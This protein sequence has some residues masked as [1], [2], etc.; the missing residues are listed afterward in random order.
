MPSRACMCFTLPRFDARSLQEGTS[1]AWIIPFS[2]L[3]GE[4]VDFEFDEDQLGLQAAAAEV[5]AKEC[6]ASYLRSVVDDGHDP[7]DLWSDLC[8]LDWPGLAI[9]A[10]AR[11]R[12]C[13]RRRA[14]DRAR[15]ARLRRRSHPVPGH[16]V[17]VRAGGCRCGDAEQRRRFLGPVATEG[18]VGALALVGAASSDRTWDPGS[19]AVEARQVGDQWELRGTASFV[20]DGDRAAE[21][22]VL[23]SDGQRRGGVRRTGNSR[24]E[25]AAPPPW[26]RPCT[27]PRSTSTE[28]RW[29]T[30]GGWPASTCRAGFE[31]ALDEA[32]TGLAMMIVGACQRALDMVDRVR[33]RPRAVRRADRVVPGGQA[34][35]RRH[36]RRHR[37]GPSARLLRRPARSPRTTPRRS[38]GRVD[39][40]GGGGRRTEAS[41]SSTASSCSAAS[42]SPGRTICTCTCAGRRPGSCSSE[43]QPSTGRG[44]AAGLRRRRAPE[45]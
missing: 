16:H 4:G 25:L 23:A 3:E 22:A 10:D 43:E 24:S 42:A 14:G 15:A 21:L 7:S 20:I 5:L 11:R 27:S 8:A 29:A 40:Q 19:P 18:R 6:P 2:P 39:G 13:L 1:R 33:Q 35:G 37:A 38:R 34:Q 9:P 28:L 45:G 32:V 30:I 41:C 36:V 12:R 17:A 44:S 31:A 26:T